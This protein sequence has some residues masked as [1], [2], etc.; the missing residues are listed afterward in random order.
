MPFSIT[1][2]FLKND[3]LKFLFT[4]IAYNFFINKDIYIYIYFCSISLHLLTGI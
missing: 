2:G 1:S 4:S 3:F